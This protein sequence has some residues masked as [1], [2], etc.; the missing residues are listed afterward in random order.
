M[1]KFSFLAVVTILFSTYAQ[2]RTSCYYSYDRWGNRTRVC[3]T[4]TYSSSTSDSVVAGAIAGATAGLVLSSCAPEVVEGNVTATDRVL[5]DLARQDDFK[6]AAKFQNLVETIV[7]TQDTKEKMALYFTL[8][9]VKDTTEIAYFLGARDNELAKYTQ[10]LEEKAD[11][12]SEQAQIVVNN[13]TTTLR[14]TLR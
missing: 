1:K 6:D 3:R 11:L 10:A 2:A 8:V 14:G 7:A 9:D 12:S 5:L 13:L 4:H